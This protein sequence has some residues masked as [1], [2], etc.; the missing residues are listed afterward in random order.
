LNKKIYHLL[1]EFPCYSQDLEIDLN[2]P[3]GRFKWFL[4]SILFGARIS[5][6]IAFRTYKAF[7]E[8]GIDTPESIL[9]SGWDKLVAILDSGGY[10]RYDFSTATKLLNVNRE[11]KERYGSLEELH[12]QSSNTEDLIK[13]LMEFKGIG[14]V[15]VS[16]FLRE[17]RGIWHVDIGTSTKAEEIARYLNIDLNRWEGEKLAR[18]ESALIKLSLRF[19]KKKLCTECPMRAYCSQI[20]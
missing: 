5:E 7:E 9:A 16:I 10:V 14:P 20:Q 2:T 3:S 17:L 11:L 8:I 15:T 18:L 1:A 4:A 6:K 13:K 19:C 12:R